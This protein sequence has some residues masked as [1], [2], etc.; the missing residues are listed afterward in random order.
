MADKQTDK[1][2]QMNRYTDRNTVRERQTEKEYRKDAEKGVKHELA[3]LH[4]P[5]KMQTNLVHH[6][7]LNPFDYNII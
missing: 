3:N 4:V 7:S 5:G 6:L 1:D 2:R